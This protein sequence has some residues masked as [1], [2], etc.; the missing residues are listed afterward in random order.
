[1]AI[2]SKHSKS[3]WNGI[4]NIAYSFLLASTFSVLL[5]EVTEMKK[6][7]IYYVTGNPIKIKTI[8]DVLSSIKEE[9]PFEIEFK[10]FDSE[11]IQSLDQKKVA[12]D[13]AE[14]AHLHFKVPIIIDDEENFLFGRVHFLFY[15]GQLIQHCFRVV[16][17][18]VIIKFS[19]NVA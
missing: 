4:K 10:N 1:M 12:L 13:K 8:Q 7:K 9:L 5:P 11:E 15:S 17:Q 3:L 18:V 14:K 19:G 6:Q 2:V 16:H